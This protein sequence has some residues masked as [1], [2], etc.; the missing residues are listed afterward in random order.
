MMERISRIE[1]F[2]NWSQPNKKYFYDDYLAI[3]KNDKQFLSFN[4]VN[5]IHLFHF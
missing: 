5:N 4:M 1:Q 3:H 2:H